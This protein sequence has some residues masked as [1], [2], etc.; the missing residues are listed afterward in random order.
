M[1]N[2]LGVGGNLGSNKS[3]GEKYLQQEHKGKAFIVTV[4]VKE[5]LR[6]WKSISVLSEVLKGGWRDL[7]R[8][9]SGG[10]LDLVAISNKFFK[11]ILVICY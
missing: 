3:I 8:P 9:E 4:C 7:K 1:I 6:K 10:D 11:S 2:Y 5:C